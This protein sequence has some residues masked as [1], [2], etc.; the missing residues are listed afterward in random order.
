MLTNNLTNCYENSTS[1]LPFPLQRGRVSEIKSFILC[2]NYTTR[3]VLMVLD[4]LSLKLY[5]HHRGI[6]M[7]AKVTLN[8][9]G[10]IRLVLTATTLKDKRDLA[11]FPFDV[12]FRLVAEYIEAPE[13]SGMVSLLCSRSFEKAITPQS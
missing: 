13:E 8:P 10:S 4:T 3:A 11:S 7:E 1:S 9:N 2:V 6:A 12:P 5:I